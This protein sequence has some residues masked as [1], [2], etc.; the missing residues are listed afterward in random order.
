MNKISV[1]ITTFNRPEMTYRAIESVI[2]N[3]LCDEIVVV[4]DFSDIEKR[5]E[6]QNTY[7][8]KL[9]AQFPV[10]YKSKL[11]FIINPENIGMSQNKNKAI[12]L[13]R[14]DKV[15]ILDSDNYLLPGFFDA[16]AAYIHMPNTI[17][18]PEK[19]LPDFIFS[20]FTNRII[21]K[22][23]IKHF[24]DV[25]MFQVLL[26]TGNYIV[27][28]NTYHSIYKFNEEIKETDTL[29]F[30]YLWLKAGYKFFVVPDMYYMH[31][32]HAGS[33]WLRNINYNLD[34]AQEIIKLIRDL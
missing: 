19:S 31:D 27:H 34:K 2:E 33:G 18:M 28:R 30:N 14:N 5:N 26:N 12:Y 9:A 24:L 22:N 25:P 17:L 29:W 20:D 4:D 3:P 15:L 16:A 10:S 6:L 1:A 32:V 23:T 11:V 21:D 8:K 7:F 13:C